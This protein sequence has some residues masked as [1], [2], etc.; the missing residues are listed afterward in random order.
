MNEVFSNGCSCNGNC[1][2]AEK[3]KKDIVIDFLYLDLSVC[4]RCRGTEK[5]LEDAVGE[6]SLLLKS[7]GYNV[8]LNK[9]NITSKELAVKYEFESSP[10]IRINGKDIDM[11]IKENCCDDCGDLCGDNVDCRIWT[12]EGVQYNVP[13]KPLIINGILKEV[14]SGNNGK[15]ASREYKIPKNLE[16]FFDGFEKKKEG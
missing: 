16:T 11:D 6:V 10:T 7:A 12:Y 8:V 4:E 14:Y 5:N 1:C 3:E 15:K 9:I 13:P 2:S